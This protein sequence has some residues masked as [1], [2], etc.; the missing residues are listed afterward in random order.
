M[1]DY[2]CLYFSLFNRLTDVIEELKEMQIEMEEMYVD[3]E[4]QTEDGLE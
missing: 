4:E 1:P 2:K 3:A